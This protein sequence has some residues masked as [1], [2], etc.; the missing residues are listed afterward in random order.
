ML[1]LAA[2][3]ISNYFT[4]YMVGIFTAIYLLFRLCSLVTRQ[5]FTFYL[6][7]VFRFVTATF[8]AIGL[9]SPLLLAVVRDLA[10]GR[11]TSGN[12]YAD[13]IT[14][15]PFIRLLTKFTNGSYSN[16]IYE[17][18]PNIYCGY[19]ALALA[20]LFFAL[21]RISLR[22]KLAAA[23]V[24]LLLLLSF[25]L[26]K[27]NYFWQ[28]F[29]AF[30]GF[31]HRYSFV[32]SFF[33][34][35]LAVR[36]LSALSFNRLLSNRHK[37]CFCFIAL[38][39]MIVVSVDMGLN[40]RAIIYG[41]ED[42][43]DYDTVDNYQGQLS[44]I[45]PL[46]D[47]ILDN[48][49]GFYRINQGYEYANNDAMLLG[50]NGMSHYSS[51]FNQKV[52]SL[53]SRLGFA[54]A[55]FWNSGHGSTPL[56]DSL[57][58]VKYYLHNVP[59]PSFYTKIKDTEYGA[60]SYLNEN[61]LSIVY[62]APLSDEEMFLDS[63]NPF[64]NQNTLLNGIAGTNLEYFSFPEFNTAG[65]D[66]AWSYSF[67]AEN[68][69]PVYLYMKSPDFSPTKVLVNG[70][71]VGGYF[72]HETNCILYLGS[73]SP[74]EKVLID[75]LPAN[76]PVHVEHIEIA[77]LNTDLL[78]STLQALMAN[79]MQ[80]IDHQSGRLKGT[81]YVPEGQKI[82]TSIPYDTGWTIKIDG[83]KVPLQK[84]AETFISVET[85]S[86]KHTVSFTYYPPGFGT[87]VI[88]FLIT[89]LVIVFYFHPDIVRLF[90][91]KGRKTASDT[92]RP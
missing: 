82:V 71:E 76:P 64:T 84:Y 54:Q 6:Q 74:E 11:L 72:S 89:L 16:I 88:I 8:L 50:F 21:R 22:E 20:L 40:G 83:E 47:N 35:Y 42:D 59:V 26:T 80:I 36:T 75:V 2:S 13:T 15:F 62:S 58:G 12:E 24:I 48:D 39:V 92:P 29:Q 77:V 43:Y 87:G 57:L 91:I 53:T 70:T 68:D 45:K 44:V 51:T 4:G 41:L 18:L 46:T 78:E 37:S 69:G 60:S 14:N 79:S 30:I 67:T 61:A 23:G 65:D 32:F 90:S 17:T 34:L 27:L 10:S 7:R 52:N 85:E 49:D 25:Y 9:A 5:T 3:F 63:D 56:T 19:I 66:S 73:F 81:I 38:L 55:H 33:M 31:S 28:G 1:F 86:G